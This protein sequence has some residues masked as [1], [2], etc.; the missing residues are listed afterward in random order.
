MVTKIFK[1]NW[2]RYFE[3]DNA[4]YL[5]NGRTAIEKALQLLGSKCVALPTYTCSR[6]YEAILNADCKPR[7]IDC[8]N[9]LQID[10]KSVTNFKDVDTV[11]VPH[12]FGIRAQE[13][14]AYLKAKGY[15]VIED[16]SQCFGLE[17][18]GKYSDVVVASIGPTKWLPIGVDK[19]SGGGIIAYNGKD[20]EW[21]NNP[22]AIHRAN[23]MFQ[24]IDKMYHSRK[25]RV[26]ELKNTG[27]NFIG[28]NQENAW[29]R[30]MYFTDNQKRIPYTPLHDKYGGF[31]CPNID[32]IKNNLEWVSIYPA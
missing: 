11:I 31:D 18:L 21:H 5:V 1:D 24:D 17:G 27:L 8:R 20:I 14:I 25:E 29:M 3:K 9:D 16:C 7:I 30:A 10:H 15:L 28:D 12:M 32:N 26:E 2:S 13:Q 19:E 23:V 22:T 6:V 4:A